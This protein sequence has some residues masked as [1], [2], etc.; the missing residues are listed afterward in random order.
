[1]STLLTPGVYRRPVAP[2]RS[3]G[4]LSRGDVPVF[5]G[6]AR[7]GPVGL[8]VRIESLTAFE[9]LFGAPLEIGHLHPALKG[10]FETG[11]HTAYVVR[12]VE[13]PT[14]EE[15]ERRARTAVTR[16]DHVAPDGTSAT[17]IWRAEAGFSWAAVD[18]RELRR[19][20]PAAEAAWVQVV[21]EVFRNHGPRTPA[22]GAWANG[23]AVRIR[24]TERVRTTSVTT[25]LDDDHALMLESL[26][27]VET[28]S[29][30]TLTQTHDI[31]ADPAS[32]ESASFTTTVV[33]THVDT[34]RQRIGLSAPVDQIVLR[35]PRPTGPDLER[36]LDPLVTVQVVSVEFDVDVYADGKLEQS[37]R[38]LSPHPR[39]SAS[40]A[41]ETVRSGRSLALLS[42]PGE[43]DW[44]DP[45]TWPPEGTFGLTGGTD[46]LS[47]VRGIDYLAV[48]P[49]VAV[50]DEVALIAAPDLVLQSQDPPEADELPAEPVDCCDLRPAEPGQLSAVIVEVDEDGVEQP[51]GGVLVDVTGPGGRAVTDT[52]GMF[53]VDGLP[54]GLVTVRLTKDGFE[55]TEAVVQSTEYLPPLAERVRLTMVRVSPPRALSQGEV[56]VVVGALADP[57]RV[58]PHKVVFADPPRPAA[59]FDELRTWRSRL[60]DSHRVGFF[61]PWL[62]LPPRESGG[63]LV[64]CPPSGHACGAFAA[65][66]LSLGIHRTGANLPLHHV[67]ALTSTIGDAEQAIANPVGINA[68]RSFPGR[69]VRLFGSRT[70]SSDPEWAQLTSRRVVDAIEKSLTRALQWM[71]FEPN[72]AMTRHAAAQTAATLLNRLW[73]EGVLA[74]EAAEQAYGVKCDLEN[75]PEEDRAAGALVVDVG[76]APTQPYEFVLFRLGT[77]H[78]ALQVTEVAQ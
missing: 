13:T 44:T 50:L 11:G 46:G 10:F 75:N 37:F 45:A 43:H 12:V 64:P 57:G 70:L 2:V 23:Y 9:Q 76:V 60:G 21:E 32:P 71:V 47:D 31:G 63:E 19:E 22:P 39:H 69:G 74:G 68:V 61:A 34:V 51:L 5:L 35:S 72:N 65:G 8:P 20:P 66:E 30:L 29:V 55:P 18:P 40:I 17:G 4:R 25:A 42:D 1:V 15:P 54:L 58:G 16:L 41:A 38:A 24:A 77:A 36:A 49:Q 3:A 48:L 28:A 78:D 26:A 27:G 33:P 67:Q 52:T 56:L 7:R 14:P 53:A 59:P 6:Y 73:R 62:L